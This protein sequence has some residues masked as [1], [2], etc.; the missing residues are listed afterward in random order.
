VKEAYDEE[1]DLGL[2][3]EKSRSK[4]TQ[5]SFGAKPK[6]LILSQVLRYIHE[7]AEQLAA[8]PSGAESSAIDR[9]DGRQQSPGQEN[10]S[11]PKAVE[12]RERS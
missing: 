7:F 12:R 6:P 2:V 3:A 1:G 4:Q 10:S 11:D 9:S 8:T 5:L